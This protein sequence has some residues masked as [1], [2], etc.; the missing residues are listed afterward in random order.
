MPQQINVGLI[1]Y[2][3][4]GKAHSQAFR[5][6]PFYFPDVK[7]SPVMKAI[8][9][10]D[11]KGVRE[12]QGQFGWQEYELD[13]RKLIERQDIG[14]I[15]IATGNNVHA[16]MAVA[17][18]QAGKHIYC[19]KPLAMNVEEARRMVDAVKKAGVINMVNFNYRAVPAIKFARQLIDEGVIGRVFHWRGFYLQDWIIDPGFPLVWRLEGDKAGSGS[20][21]DLAAHLIDLAHYLV[22]DIDEV[23]GL[24]ETFVKQ[25]P[26]LAATT[27]GLTAAA[28]AEMGEVTVDDASLF[29][30]KFKNGAVGTFE[31]TRFAAGHRNGNMF[32]INGEKGSIRFNVERM[33]E[34]EFYD[35][36]DPGD[37]QGFRVIAATEGAHPWMGA[38][39]PPAHIIGWAQTFTHQVYELLNG[40]AG[41]TCPHPN[42]EDGLKCQMVLEAVTRSART[43]EWVKLDS[44]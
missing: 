34:I 39:W 4:M 22:G 41:N 19:E 5:D 17:A 12:A 3:F 24:Q 14:L 32:E 40:I 16:E 36:T 6:V 42:F 29:L 33:N 9:G 8:C 23:S 26:K 28:S 38:W 13:Y 35:H 18:A 10:R 43:R 7:L 31:A 37:R 11:E 44:I 27:G 30:A 21:G 15:D 2:K 1:G 25:R 20:H